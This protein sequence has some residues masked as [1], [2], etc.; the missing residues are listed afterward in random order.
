[1]KFKF[2]SILIVASQAV[3]GVSGDSGVPIESIDALQ[4]SPLAPRGGVLMVQLVTESNGDGW[5]SELDVTFED[6]TIQKGLVGWIE[7]NKNTAAWTINPLIIRP[8]TQSDN[9]LLVHP[10]DVTTG[11]VL[12]FELP[13]HG[14]GNISF[15]GT[16]LSPRWIDLPTSLP[17][18][19]ITTSEA[20]IKLLPESNDDLPEWN[21][22]EYW[23]WTLVASKR[24]KI[25]PSPPHDSEVEKLA[26]LQGAYLWRFGFDRLARSSRAVAATCRDL[27]TNTV[28][29]GEHEYACWVVQPHSLQDLLSILHDTSISSR[30]LATRALRWAEVQRLYLQ[31]LERVYGE[32]VTLAIANPTLEPIVAS[33]RWQDKTDIPIAVEVPASETLRAEIARPPVIDHSVFGPVSPESQLQWMSVSIGIQSQSFPIVTADVV[34]LPP[35]VQFSMLHPLWN[36]QSVQQG[37]PTPVTPDAR[38][39]VQ[40]RRVFGVWEL[41]FQ[42]NGISGRGV[43]SNSITSINQVRGVEAVSIICPESESLIVITPSSQQI[44]S[45]MKIH[46]TINVDGWS[47]RVELPATWVENEQLSFSVARTHGNTNHVETAP[48]PCLPWNINP[49]PIVVDVSEWDRIIQIP[50]SN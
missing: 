25:T 44:E 4:I 31:W 40:L 9:T 43:L 18:F 13:V 30:Q 21:A 35:N 11:P 50:T 20:K 26:A 24:N 49:S 38:T 34:A 46:R 12:L 36:L 47:I 37:I 3:Q 2:A 15:G 42:C 5:P 45:G 29:D 28:F 39:S 48:L 10:K 1:M 23:R 14:F 27:L 8:I 19:G 6:G 41:F 22:L 16:T 17:D 33:I 32:N 7:K